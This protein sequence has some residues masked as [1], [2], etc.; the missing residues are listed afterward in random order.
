MVIQECGRSLPDTCCYRSCTYPVPLC[1]RASGHSSEVQFPLTPRSKERTRPQSVP[2]T[3]HPSLRK[4]PPFRSVFIY[5]YTQRT[6]VQRLHLDIW[7]IFAQAHCRRAEQLF[8]RCFGLRYSDPGGK[9]GKWV[10]VERG[11]SIEVNGMV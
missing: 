10:Q 4:I 1:K 8:D 2:S 7:H 6:H 3:S 5:L 11:Y 9:I